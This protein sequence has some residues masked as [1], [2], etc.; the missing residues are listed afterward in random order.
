[1]SDWRWLLEGRTTPWYPTVRIFRQPQVGDWSPVF[2]AIAAELRK[3]IAAP[4]RPRV[5]RC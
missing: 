2:E 5:T 1:V 4:H 3:L